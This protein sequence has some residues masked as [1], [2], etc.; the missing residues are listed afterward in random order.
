VTVG[1]PN[2]NARELTSPALHDDVDL[3]AVPVAEMMEADVVLMP[4][5]LPAELP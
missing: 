2:L 4:T 5:R 1:R 3:E